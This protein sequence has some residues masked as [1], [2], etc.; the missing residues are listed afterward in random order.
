MQIRKQD[1]IMDVDVEK[2]KAYAQ[3]H[4]V[5][6]CAEDRNFYT[7]AKEKFPQLDVFLDELGV[8]I[9]RPDETGCVELEEEREIDYLFVSYTVCGKVLGLDKYEID[10]NDGG[11][12]LNIVIG[13]YYVPNEQT[14]DYFVVGVYGI[15]L[16]WVLDEPFPMPEPFFK[17][18]LWQKIKSWFLRKPK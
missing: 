4:S 5:C 17:T 3:S 18:S 10:M 2:T 11:L 13:D 6:D 12:F 1:C 9:T 8:D 15:R 7:Q 14:G 16:P